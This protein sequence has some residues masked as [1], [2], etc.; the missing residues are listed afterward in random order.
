MVRTQIQLPDKLYNQA[1]KIAKT[2]EISLA[3]LVRRGL[4]YIVS[5]SPSNAAPD[6]WT[7]PP[8]RHLGGNDPFRDDDWRIKLH[9]DHTETRRIA[10][11]NSQYGKR[12]PRE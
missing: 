10:G 9:M 2:G 12:K 1:R 11:K 4:E 5:V 6:E 7:L 8:A 3:E